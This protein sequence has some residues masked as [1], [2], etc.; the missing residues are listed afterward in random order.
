MSNVQK[1]LDERNEHVDT[2]E[3]VSTML[4]TSMCVCECLYLWGVSVGERV[5]VSKERNG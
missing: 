1:T 2:L 4:C 3:Q 5:C